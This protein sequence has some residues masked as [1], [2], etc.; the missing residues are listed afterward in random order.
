MKHREWFKG[1]FGKEPMSMEEYTEL[2]VKIIKLQLELNDLKRKSHEQEILQAKW[3]SS[4]YA[5]NI[6]QDALSEKK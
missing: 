5:W 2:G 6:M 1:Q 3:E 4:R